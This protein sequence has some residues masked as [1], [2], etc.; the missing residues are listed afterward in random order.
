MTTPEDL[1]RVQ[2]KSVGALLD[3][4]ERIVLEA[5]INMEIKNGVEKGLK[6]YKRFNLFSEWAKTIGWAGLIFFSITAL[7]GFIYHIDRNTYYH[8]QYEKRAA[9]LH[10]DYTKKINKCKSEFET[11]D[12]ERIQV[13]DA[14]IQAIIG[15]ELGAKNNKVENALH[16]LKK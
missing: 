15:I 13:K 6:N 8:N 3:N 2:K 1:V 4:D 5:Y 10:S 7:G 16:T 14:C 11:C 9:N 12:L